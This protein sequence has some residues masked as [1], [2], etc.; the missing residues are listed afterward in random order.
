MAECRLHNRHMR[1]V[2]AEVNLD[3]LQPLTPQQIH[4]VVTVRECEHVTIKQLAQKLYV[5][6]PAASTMVDRLVEMGILTRGENPDDRREVLVQVSPA[7][8][9]LIQEIERKHLQLTVD[10]ID[11][12]GIEHARMWGEVCKRIQDTLSAE[13]TT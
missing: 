9:T 12:I 3:A 7:E 5:K 11:T 1:R 2:F 4:A 6:A 13:E 8:E 10:L